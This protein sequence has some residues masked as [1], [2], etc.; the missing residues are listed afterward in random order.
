[1]TGPMTFEFFS[2]LMVIIGA[3]CGVGGFLWMRVEAARKTTR[4]ELAAEQKSRQAAIDALRKE[5]NDHRVEVARNYASKDTLDKVE[6][7]IGE[8]LG[9]VK[10][11]VEAL[12]N[13][14]MKLAHA[15]HIR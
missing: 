6:E 13:E 10:D 12:R 8:G 2:T 7:R 1:M 9:E 11:Q 3:I 4:D 14:V 5:F 15:R